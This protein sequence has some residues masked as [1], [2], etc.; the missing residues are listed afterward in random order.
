MNESPE[1]DEPQHITIGGASASLRIALG[2]ATIWLSSSFARPWYEDALREGGSPTG[3]GDDIRG[4]RRREVLFAV[5][6]SETYLVEWVRDEALG[7]D[8][9][10]L[11][12]YFP[13]R[14]HRGVTQKWKEVPKLL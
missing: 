4:A 9:T 5:I 1:R 10:K 13:A 12:S 3:T 8:F 6:F 7:R 2:A 11:D 14:P